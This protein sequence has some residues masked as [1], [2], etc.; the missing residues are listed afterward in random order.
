MKTGAI[1]TYLK[2]KMPKILFQYVISIFKTVN[3]L[4]FFKLP[5]F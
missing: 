4:Y 1:L 2:P 3:V 5:Q